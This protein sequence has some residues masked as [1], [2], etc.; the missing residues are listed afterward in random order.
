[1]T[2]VETRFTEIKPVTT[3]DTVGGTTVTGE[4]TD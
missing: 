2:N 4:V 1:M 3:A